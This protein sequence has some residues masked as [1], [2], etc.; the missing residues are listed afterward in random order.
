MFD[1]SWSRSPVQAVVGEEALSF[2]APLNHFSWCDS[3]LL[4]A[5]NRK[6]STVCTPLHR[7]LR[8]DS[9]KIYGAVEMREERLRHI[10]HQAVRRAVPNGRRWLVL[11]LLRR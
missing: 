3:G 8:G 2:H 6:K 5:G 10:F 1:P 4:H 11:H 7:Q 9:V